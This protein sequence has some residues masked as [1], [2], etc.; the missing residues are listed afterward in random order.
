MI[1]AAL[2]K[3]QL[4]AVP[5]ATPAGRLVGASGLLLECSGCALRTGQRCSIETAHGDWL[6]AEVVGFRDSVSFLMA[7]KS[8]EGLA[9]G[10]LV[11][12]QSDRTE[13]R[14]GPSWLGRAVNGLG[15]PIDG[16]GVWRATRFS[17]P[18]HA[19]EFAQEKAC[20]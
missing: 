3:L 8:S 10:A 18:G 9:T 16:K 6:D 12:P 4:A 11:L 13:L 2:R 17:S 5:I 19:G 20:P 1:S 15:E 14:I 7:Y